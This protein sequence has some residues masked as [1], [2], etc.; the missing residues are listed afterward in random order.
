[1]LGIGGRLAAALLFTS[2][3]SCYCFSAHLLELLSPFLV[4][5]KRGKALPIK[6]A[7]PKPSGSEPKVSGLVFQ[8]ALDR[9]VDQA[10][11]GRVILERFSI[12]TEDAIL[13]RREPEVA[14]LIFQ[15]G[16][17]TVAHQAFPLPE[18]GESFSIIAA[19]PMPSCPK[20]KVARL[21]FCDRIDHVI[22]KVVLGGR[23][24]GGLVNAAIGP[25]FGT[26]Y[27]SSV[28]IRLVVAFG[29]HIIREGVAIIAPDATAVPG[30][31]PDVAAF[32]L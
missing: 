24:S 9:I 14:L 2:G 26:A 28:F 27:A 8:D 11:I 23:I 29:R 5:R 4:F 16:T 21:V 18:A 20:P 15:D 19:S 25:L 12:I 17:N 1:M 31:E 6:T 3:F 13:V 22:G 30:A 32:V 7:Q 10:V